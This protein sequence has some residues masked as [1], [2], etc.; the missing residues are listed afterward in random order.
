MA[1]DAGALGT[2]VIECFYLPV[3]NP[4]ATGAFGSTRNMRLR[5]PGRDI[6]VVA[7]EA[8]PFEQWRDLLTEYLVAPQCPRNREHEC[9]KE[10]S[11]RSL[12]CPHGGRLA[13][14][15]RTGEDSANQRSL[16][17]YHA[18]GS[19]PIV[20]L[21]NRSNVEQLVGYFVA[22]AYS[23]GSGENKSIFLTP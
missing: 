12:K 15:K 20:S 18:S 11:G 23:L 5:F 19:V 10:N 2:R 14:D 21:A 1:G 13:E 8:A 9:R 4:V 3:A 16:P 22:Q 7:G 17:V 6:A